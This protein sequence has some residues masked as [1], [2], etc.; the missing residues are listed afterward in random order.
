MCALIH[1]KWSF[2]WWRHYLCRQQCY[3]YEHTDCLLWHTYLCPSLSFSFTPRT[4][5]LS[6]YPLAHLLSLF[7]SLALS[8]YHSF[9]RA[10]I[11]ITMP[12]HF[13][14]SD[15]CSGA[16]RETMMMMSVFKLERTLQNLPTEIV[17]KNMERFNLHLHP[18]R[19]WPDRIAEPKARRIFNNTLHTNLCI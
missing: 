5:S 6:P 16:Q 11:H 8:L 2:V 10:C 14:Y 13:M 9:S 4:L 15:I 17:N 3:M 7:I 18:P 12:K 19:T 1:T